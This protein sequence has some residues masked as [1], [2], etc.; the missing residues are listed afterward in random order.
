MPEETNIFDPAPFLKTLTHQPGVYRMQ[1]ANGQLL[2]V[3]KAKDLKKRVSSYFTRSQQSSRIQLM[4]KQ[5]GGVE[6]TVTN[7]EAEAL[8]LENNLIKQ[9]RPRYNILLRDD[10][11]YPYIYLSSQQRFPRLS[12]YRGARSMK[13]EFYGPYTS[14][15][16]VRETLNILQKIFKVRQCQDA[17]FKNR[18]RPCLQYQIDRCTAPC[19]GLIDEERYAKDVDYARRFL[20]GKSQQITQ[21]LIEEMELAADKQAYEEAAQLR[22]RVEA[23]RQVAQQQYVSDADGDCDIIACKVNDM[24]ACVQVFNIRNGMNLGNKT[25]YPKVPYE[26][27]EAS[28]LTAFIGQYY[29]SRVPPAELI[30]FPTP[31]DSAV[32]QEMLTRKREKKVTISSSVRSRRAKWLEIAKRNVKTAFEAKLASKTGMEQRFDALQETLDHADPIERIEC[33]DISHTQ[34]ELT[35]ASCV[36][37]NREGPLKADYRKFNIEGI[38]GGDDYAAMR[39]ALTRRYTR[40]KKGEVAAPDILFIDG[41]KGQLSQ[42]LEVMEELQMTDMMLVGVA[43]GVER[44]PGLEQ[45]FVN[46]SKTALQLSSGSLALHLI[47]QIRDEA[48]R[49]AITGHRKRRQKART[50][51][52]L[53]DIPGLGPKRRQALLKHFGG[54]RGITRASIDELAKINGISKTLAELVYNALHGS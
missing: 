23:L 41:G 32:L 22:D 42:A 46:D 25:Y 37:F 34:G 10:K 38:Q 49:F 48:H 14:V 29:V 30:V 20:Q 40:I 1:S 43:K 31:A 33:F 12:F 18:S 45:L 6:V 13:G 44:R 8:L 2:Y 21:K 51:S 36:V 52:P 28:L 47:Q 4:M 9:H 50:R 3:G 27:N 54:M 15:A 17:F 24:L 35:V 53:E 39:Q 16:A 19:V 7:S 5:V 26:V 11:S